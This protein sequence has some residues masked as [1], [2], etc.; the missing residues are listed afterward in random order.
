MRKVKIYVEKKVD[1]Q[2]VENKNNSCRLFGKMEK[3]FCIFVK[4][5]TKM[6]F[7]CKKN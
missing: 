3:R 7:F 2:V 6:L 5:K 4:K 1:L